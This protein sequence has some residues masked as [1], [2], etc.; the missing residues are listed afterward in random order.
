MIR[1]LFLP[2]NYGPVIQ[3]GVYD[4]FREAGCE[5]EVFDY[6]KVYEK[7]RRKVNNVRQQFIT[8]AMQ[9][10]P[11]LLHLQIQHTTVIDAETIAKI[12]RELPKCIVTNWTGDV[13]NYVPSSFKKIAAVA[14]YNLISSTG[15]L[16]MFKKEI[17]KD[18][19]YWQIGYNPTLYYPEEEPRQS[20][21]W[22]VTFIAN[23]NT[24]E[25]YPGRLI[26]EDICKALRKEFGSKFCLYGHGWPRS[27]LSKGDLDQRK[28][29]FAYHNSRCVISV[30]HYNNLSHYFSDRLLMCLASGR[31]T[32]ALNFPRWESYFTNNCDLLVA[33]SVQEVVEKVRYLKNNPYFANFV[34]QSGADKVWAEHTYLSRINELLDIVGLQ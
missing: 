23:N 21:E 18:I 1:V 6:F 24:K 16:S 29:G 30:S 10:R 20:F 8:R 19:K 7:N 17:A 2:L 22:D 15:Q 9:F 4:A 12:K 34:G 31:P 25:R 33:N 3:S 26:R 28:V 13:R 32:V 14:D 11:D 5:L 27:L